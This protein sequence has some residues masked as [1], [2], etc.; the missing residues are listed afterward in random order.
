[1]TTLQCQLCPEECVLEDYQVGRCRV[2]I[3]RDGRL[4]SLVYGKPCAV[5]V[6]PIEKKPIFHMLPATTAFSLATAGC[7]LSCKFCQ[8]WEIS[9]ASPE[10]TRSSDLSPEGVVDLAVERGCRSIAYT[11]SEPVV[12]YEYMFDTAREAHRRGLRNIWVTGA[13]I[14]AE[15]LRE[16]AP[17]IDAANI[18]LKGFTEDYYREVCGGRLQPVLDA[19]ELSAKLGILVELT[20]LIVPTLN[21]DLHLIRE[22]CLW[23]RQTLGPDVPLHFSRFHPQYRL[24]KLPPTPLETLWKAHEIALECGLHYVYT[25]NV[26]YDERSNTFCPSCRRR[27][28]TRVGFFVTEN[29]LRGGACPFCGA[30]I[31][32]IWI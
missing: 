19:I 9:Q 23:I 21:D 29:R 4:Y 24:R 14:N 31:A 6:D 2:R 13:Y 25:G 16:L 3:N 18:D 27:L 7:N 28:I 32:G 26:P 10:K 5:H 15:P 30:A 1:V 12:F 11:Y 22:M 20:N 17:Y 8:N